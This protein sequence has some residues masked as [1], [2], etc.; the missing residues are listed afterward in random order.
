MEVKLLLLAET[1]LLTLLAAQV[2]VPVPTVN[3]RVAPFTE[4][5]EAV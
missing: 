1:K 5:L 3:A 2:V 4:S